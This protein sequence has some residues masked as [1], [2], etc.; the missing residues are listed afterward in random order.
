MFPDS[1]H[2][3]TTCRIN[4]LLYLQLT[5]YQHCILSPINHPETYFG[6]QHSINHYHQRDICDKN[7]ISK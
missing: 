1:I 4:F 2:I 7:N 5:C 3:K 6:A